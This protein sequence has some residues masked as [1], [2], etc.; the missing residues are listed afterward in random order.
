MKRQKKMPP[1][2]PSK[3]LL[4]D[5]LKPL[6]ISQYLLAKD[7]R[8]RPR[9]INEIV[10]GTRSVTADTALRLS[11]YFGTTDRLWLNSRLDRIYRSRRIGLAIGLR[12]KCRCLRG[13]VRKRLQLA[14]RNNVPSR[15]KYSCEL[16]RKILA[17]GS[18]RNGLP[19]HFFIPQPELCINAPS[20]ARARV[21]PRPRARTHLRPLNLSVALADLFELIQM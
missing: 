16:E 13:R 6:G 2:H 4:E 21:S 14:D 12:E 5:F 7:L 15:F 8:V 17:P 19:T 11:R 20:S 9:R 10:H 18:S 1:I 3:L